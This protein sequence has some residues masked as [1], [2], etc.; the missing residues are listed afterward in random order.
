MQT[1]KS[2]CI[3]PIFTVEAVH[4]IFSKKFQLLHNQFD[5]KMLP[6]AGTICRIASFP[7]NRFGKPLNSDTELQTE[8]ISWMEMR[9]NCINDLM[10]EKEEKRWERRKTL[11][12]SLKS[13]EIL[14]FP[15]LDENELKIFSLAATNSS[16]PYRI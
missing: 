16:S 3:L 7:L 10:V 1:A 8:I 14:D 13:T 15:E 12:T 5:N 4:G 9:R 2:P 11:F 6:K